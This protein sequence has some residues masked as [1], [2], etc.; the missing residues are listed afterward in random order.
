MIWLNPHILSFPAFSVGNL[1]LI[2]ESG[3]SLEKEMATHSSILAWEIPWTEEPGGL[4]S[5]GPQRVIHD[6]GTSLH[7]NVPIRK[8]EVF[9]SFMV[10]LN[11]NILNIIVVF[12][13]T[14]HDF[15]HLLYFTWFYFIYQTIKSVRAKDISIFDC[16]CTCISG[17]S[18][19]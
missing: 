15:I 12:I 10:R 2:P 13:N 17:A 7:L 3:R 11:P 14:Y 5:M 9:L 8:S 4:Q 16:Q 1:G 18:T 6:W 19:Q